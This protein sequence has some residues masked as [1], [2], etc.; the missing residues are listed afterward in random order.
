MGK[1]DT[2]NSKRFKSIK[3]DFSDGKDEYIFE[4][5]VGFSPIPR[6]SHK[7]L[8][9]RRAVH[10]WWVQQFFDIFV[11]KGDTLHLILGD[12]PAVHC[13]VLRDLVLIELF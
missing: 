1:D 8:G 12:N 11:K 2:F 9:E 13:F 4:C 6:S 5:W 3:G 7:K 10:T